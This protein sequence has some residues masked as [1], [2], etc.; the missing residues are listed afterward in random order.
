MNCY[1]P[2]LLKV[3]C[4]SLNSYVWFCLWF[5]VVVG[6]FRNILRLPDYD[7]PDPA[8][9]DAVCPY[10]QFDFGFPSS[11]ESQRPKSPTWIASGNLH[12]SPARLYETLLLYLLVS[13]ELAEC[14]V[15]A[16][17]NFSLSGRILTL[18]LAFKPKIAETNLSAEK[19]LIQN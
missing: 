4:T 14:L 13:C 18:S 6:Y 7:M 2:R 10:E 9:K 1:S 16:R 3:C 15:S 11:W 12:C 17:R 5:W 8:P 19:T